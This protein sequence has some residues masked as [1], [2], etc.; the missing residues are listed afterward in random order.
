MLSCGSRFPQ[1]SECYYAPIEGDTL[2]VTRGLKKCKM[3][4]LGCP[5]F[6]I[7]VN[8]KPLLKIVGVSYLFGSEVTIIS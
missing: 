8:H 7:F 2:A 5:M 1:P 3:F 4:L 6:Y